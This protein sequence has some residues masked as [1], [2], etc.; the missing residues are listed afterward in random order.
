[1][2]DYYAITD[3]S[4]LSFIHYHGASYLTYS[5]MKKWVAK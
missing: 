2:K 4:V 1:M 3:N 5:W